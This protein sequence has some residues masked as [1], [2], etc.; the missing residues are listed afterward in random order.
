MGGGGGGLTAEEIVHA[1]TGHCEI[2]VGGN[3]LKTYVVYCIWP[4]VRV[5]RLQLQISAHQYFGWLPCR[6]VL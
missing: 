6:R 2:S 5:T 4:L 3:K 1:N